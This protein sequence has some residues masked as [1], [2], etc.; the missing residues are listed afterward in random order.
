MMSE[1]FK[2]ID[3]ANLK[4]LEALIMQNIEKVRCS[5]FTSIYI[6]SCTKNCE[7][8]NSC[9]NFLV[10]SCSLCAVLLTK[11]MRLTVAI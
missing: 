10:L 4:L 3:E 9:P 11:C 2:N 8:H 6:L 5:C 1:A 7:F